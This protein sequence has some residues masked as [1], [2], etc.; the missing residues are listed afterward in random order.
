MISC[1]NRKV[2]IWFAFHVYRS[3][4]PLSLMIPSALPGS[5]IR[6]DLISM[7]EYTLSSILPFVRSGLRR[8]RPSFTLT[9]YA[10]ATWT[11]SG[12]RTSAR[13]FGD[14]SGKR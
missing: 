11:E 6:Y 4:V 2:Q 13:V 3:L 1:K 8:V 7:P 9:E 12:Y 10:N 14:L 5:Y